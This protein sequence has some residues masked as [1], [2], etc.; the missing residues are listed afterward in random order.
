M[1][2]KEGCH[3]WTR[4]EYLKGMIAAGATF[5]LGLPLVRAG[6]QEPDVILRITAKPDVVPIWKGE[7]TAVF[8]YVGEVMKGRQDALRPSDSYLGPII[9]V[10]KG[11]RVRIHFE[12]ALAEASNIHWHGL[13]VP[14][15]M[16]G[17]PRHTAAPG[18]RYVYEFEIKDRAGTYWFHP[19]PHGRTG[20]QVYFGL[21]G[22]FIVSDE[23]EQAAQLPAGEYDLP[24]ILQDRS[25]DKENR[26][27]FLSD[28]QAGR[29]MMGGG[30]MGGGMMGGGMMGG[31]MMGSGMMDMMTRMMGF[32]GDR[33]LVNGRPDATLSV[34]T[35][36]YRFRLLNGS[37]ARIF[38]LAWDDGSPL[39]VIGTD[40]GLLE[41]PAQRSYVTL[42]PGER[43]ELW[44]DFSRH[45]VG[46]E[47]TMRSLPF[48]GDMAMGGGMMGGGM[49]GG[50]MMGMMGNQKLPNGAAFPVFKVR[51]ERREKAPGALP[52]RLSTIVRH[53]AEDAVNFRRPRVFNITMGMMQWGVNGR[54]FEMEGVADDEIVRLNTLEIWEFTND[55]SMGMMGMMAHPMHI[56]GLQFQILERSVKPAFAEAVNSV[57]AGYVDE[58]WKDEVFLMPG[59]RAKVLLA[60]KDFGGIFPYHCHMLEH[61]ETG[62]MRN[63]RVS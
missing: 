13:H 20:R 24:L 26:L 18:K 53:R 31:D 10:R 46:T 15:D 50:G 17:H 23:E 11:Q 47:L 39:T 48:A 49:M 57:S 59:E 41:A 34:A 42:A 62:L 44:A 4:R 61:A 43:L 55:A 56:H 3:M 28:G 33:I 29:G 58:G 30:M 37:N 51:V 63:Y 8:R 19:H 22:L 6:E 40:G 5:G 25:F 1:T 52:K 45:A 16:D 7:P 14:D 36:P 2:N 54:S 32:L 38:K 35:R 60:F 9:R 12:N 27:V 21:A